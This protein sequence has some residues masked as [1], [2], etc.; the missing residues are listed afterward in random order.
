[1]FAFL[2]K[3]IAGG[4][5]MLQWLFSRRVTKDL[6]KKACACSGKQ[7]QLRGECVWVDFP[8][9]GLLINYKIS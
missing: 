4:V 5:K 8:A 7:R 9:G 1:M 6:G 3:M 2:T